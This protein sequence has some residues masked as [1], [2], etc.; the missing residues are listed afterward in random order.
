MYEVQ[1]GLNKKNV[2]ALALM[3]EDEML[4]VVVAVRQRIKGLHRVLVIGGPVVKNSNQAL[5]ALLLDELARRWGRKALYTE[6]RP[7]Y[8]LRQLKDAFTANGWQYVPHYSIKLNLEK[9]KEDL[10]QEMHKERRRNVSQAEKYGLRF[11][12]IISK[13]DRER[14]VELLEQTYRRK[15]IP[16]VDKDILNQLCVSM[17]D[18][19]RFFAA[20]YEDKMLAGQVRLCYKD[21]IYAW[22]AG[23]DERF[24]KMRPNDFLMW[25][26]ICWAKDKGYR[27]FDFGG[28]G[29]PGKAYGVRDY[30]LKYG[31]ELLE[32]GRWI[33]THYKPAYKLMIWLKDK[34][35]KH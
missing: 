30:K 15:N 12:E 2:L 25:N 23:S 29:E 32:E 22:Y 14:V 34:I 31:A 8:D 26:V 18:N 27:L 13:E 4:G 1:R 33:Y 16:L 24:F 17:P 6:V 9:E 10:W 3:Y 7:V 11:E 20:F 5:A 35:A 21:L 19:I 28:G